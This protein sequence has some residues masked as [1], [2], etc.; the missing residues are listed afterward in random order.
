MPIKVLVVDDTT[1]LREGIKSLLAKN[2]G[3]AFVGEAT[4]AIEA[5][6]Q[7][8][9]MSPDVVLLDQD[10]PG[11]DCF[12]AVR[13]IKNRRPSTEIIIL[14][15]ATDHEQ[16]LRLVEA[17]ASGYVLKDINPDNL[18]RAIEGVCNG[19]TLMNPHV[20]RQLVERFRTLAREHN[21]H[22]GGHLGG[23]TGREV[24]I[25]MELTKG[26]TDREI[27]GKMFVTIT[28]VKSHIRSI[29]RKIGAKNRTQAVV[30]VLKNGL[31]H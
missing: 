9:A 31:A 2:G 26:A 17:G 10:I 5:A 6:E 16:A 7:T 25:L 30:Y 21:G 22:N 15:E 18:V 12:D 4:N 27:A 1:L 20:A 29:F 3:I 28:T 24:E 14:A 13:L 11:L 23:L 19:R 8:T